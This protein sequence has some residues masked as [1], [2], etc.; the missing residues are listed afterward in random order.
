M[1]LWVGIDPGIFGAVAATDGDGAEWWPLPI[2]GGGD[3]KR[4]LNT[5]EFCALMGNLLHRDD[6]RIVMERVGAMPGQGTTSMF[7]F[8][9]GFGRLEGVLVSMGLSFSLVMPQ[10]WKKRVLEGTSKD[11]AAAVKYCNA[12]WP[13]V[14]LIPFNGRSVSDGA[15]DALCMADYARRF[16]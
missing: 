9:R 1:T 4:E 2:I 5:R 6:L 13:R 3:T 15:A 7:N 8:G 16:A 10:S 12:R 14:S 11:K